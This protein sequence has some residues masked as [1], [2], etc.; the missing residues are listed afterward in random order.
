MEIERKYLVLNSDFKIEGKSTLISQGYLNSN[1][2]RTVRVRIN[3]NKAFLTIKSKTK[4]FSRD[5]F[6]YEIPLNDASYLLNNICEKPIIEKRIFVI[7]FQNNI[8]EIDEFHGENE[9]LVI[10]EIELE[11]EDQKFDKPSWVG[12]EVSAD[13]KYFNSSLIKFPFK[14]WNEKDKS[15]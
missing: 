11:A 9:G 2:N 8:W 5:E 1:E 12:K 7:N 13:T 4:G 14:N 6:E 15:I 3:D 10:A